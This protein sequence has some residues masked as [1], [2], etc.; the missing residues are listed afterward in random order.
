ML[1]LEVVVA[2][3]VVVV[4]VVVACSPGSPAVEA[5]P[6]VGSDWVR[7]TGSVSGLRR[8]VEGS[9]AAVCGGLAEGRSVVAAHRR[10]AGGS[11]AVAAGRAERRAEEGRIGRLEGA[12][13]IAVIDLE[14]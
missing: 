5:C 8:R 11:A 4:V 6:G 3:V 10:E 13:S 1:F 14:A 7:H 9:V 12:R 2:V